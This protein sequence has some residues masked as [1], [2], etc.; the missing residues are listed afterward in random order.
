MSRSLRTLRVPVLGTFAGVTGALAASPALAASSFVL[1][2]T[3]AEFGTREWLLSG[4]LLLL[5]VALAGRLMRGRAAPRH[6]RVVEEAPDLRW[7]RN[8]MSAGY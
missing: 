3:L 1:Q 6:A 4:A 8:S 2:N 5:V 7:W